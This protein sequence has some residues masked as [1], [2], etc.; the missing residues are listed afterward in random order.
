ME[1]GRNAAMVLVG[2]SVPLTPLWFGQGIASLAGTSVINP[3]GVWR[4]VAQG[5]DKSIF[6]EGAH[7]VK[8]YPEDVR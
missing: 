1:L 4:H 8:L 6:S 2:P 3:E 5:G 7:M